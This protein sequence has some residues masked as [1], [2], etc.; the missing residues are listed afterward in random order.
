MKWSGMAL[1]LILCTAVNLAS[2]FW[3]TN[4]LDA[5]DCERKEEKKVVVLYVELV[6]EMVAVKK[7]NNM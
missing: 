1:L 4:V 3:E 5:V 2:T 6:V 7:K